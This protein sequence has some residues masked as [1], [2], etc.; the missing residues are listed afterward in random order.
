[1][2]FSTKTLLS[3]LA[4]GCVSL[5]TQVGAQSLP[6]TPLPDD[7]DRYYWWYHQVQT[8]EILEN[9]QAIVVHPAHQ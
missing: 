9:M 4:V 3:A 6:L 7:G 8:D 2:I 5:A 1:M